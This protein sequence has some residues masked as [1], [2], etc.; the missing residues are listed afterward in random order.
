MHAYN[1]SYEGIQDE[2]G[3]KGA[4]IQGAHRWMK[5]PAIMGKTRVWPVVSRGVLYRR[6][7]HVDLDFDSVEHDDRMIAPAI[8]SIH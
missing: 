3:G 8:S 1:E 6:A 4:V 2:I 7:M 5:L